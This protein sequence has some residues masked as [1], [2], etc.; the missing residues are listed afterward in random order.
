MGEFSGKVAIV[1]GGAMGI[2]GATSRAFGA[3]G[4]SVVVADLAVAEAEA[5]VAEIQAAGGTAMFV[6]TDISKADD[7][8]ALVKRTVEAYGGLDIVFN[9]A[10]IQP[11][12]SYTNVEDMPEEV[13]DRIIAVNLKSRFLV[14]KYAIPE[15]R[16]RGGGVIVNNASVQGLQSMPLVPAYAA[17]K[18]GDLS[19]TRQ[20][21]LDYAAENIRVVAVCPGAIDTPMVRASIAAETDDMAKGLADSGKIHPLGRIGQ[22]ED[23]ANAVLFLASDR[24]SFITGSYILVDGGLMALGAW[25]EGPGGMDN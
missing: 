24:A 3:A 8:A 2:G 18:G 22:G 9:N 1:T 16:K 12:T 4:A 5:T 14:A 19:L 15:M 23:I 13:W 20:M 11:A 21:A 25:A 10:G 6:A 17:S 7:C